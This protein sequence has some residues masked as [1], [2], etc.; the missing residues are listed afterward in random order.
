MDSLETQSNTSISTIVTE[1]QQDRPVV[2]QE[3]VKS[4]LVDT[5]DLDKKFKEFEDL[6][7][8]MNAAIG[9]K[10]LIAFGGGKGE[11]SSYTHQP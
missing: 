5:S 4:Y 11:A 2:Q 10:L 8:Q 1:K 3:E 9:E 6:F 7:R